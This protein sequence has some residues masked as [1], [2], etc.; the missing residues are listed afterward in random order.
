MVI[1]RAILAGILGAIL[2]FF[3]IA[4]DVHAVIIGAGI[5]VFSY[6]LGCMNKGE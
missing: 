3:A 5:A 2:S 6:L 1:F 4:F